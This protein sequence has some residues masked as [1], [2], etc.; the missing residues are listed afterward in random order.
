MNYFLPPPSRTKT[1]FER[2]GGSFLNNLTQAMRE[3]EPIGRQLAELNQKIDAQYQS[4][5]E[6]FGEEH[7][8]LIMEALLDSLVEEK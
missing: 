4:M 7:A 6:R 8:S 3:L 5:V 1:T 2:K